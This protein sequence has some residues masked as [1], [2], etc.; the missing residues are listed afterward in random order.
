MTTKTNLPV[1]QQAVEAFSQ[2]NGEPG[3]LSSLRLD[4]LAKADD[5]PLPKPDKTKID[6]LIF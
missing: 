5:L 6:K 2:K 1:D 3:W 4:A